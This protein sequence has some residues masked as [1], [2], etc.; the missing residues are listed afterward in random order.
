MAFKI[1][2]ENRQPCC[3]AAKD[4]KVKDAQPVGFTYFHWEIM[5]SL[6]LFNL[7]SIIVKI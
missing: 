3:C 5:A 7:N 2:C 1:I 4:K 6:L